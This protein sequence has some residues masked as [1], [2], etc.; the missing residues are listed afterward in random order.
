[1]FLWKE[2]LNSDGHKF[3]Q[4][5][6][7]EQSPLILTELTEH[8]ED[9]VM[10]TGLWIWQT[11]TDISATVSLVMMTIVNCKNENGGSFHLV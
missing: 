6:Q 3:H 10:R 2:S 5:Q 8:K 7:N 9:H 4:Y 1:M 11:V